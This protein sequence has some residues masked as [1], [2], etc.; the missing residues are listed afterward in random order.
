MNAIY[1]D[2][3]STTPVHP[4][5]AAAI[6]RCFQAGHVNPASSHRP[7]QHA[8]RIVEKARHR[9]AATLGAQTSGTHADH[10]IFTSGGTEA[11]NLALRGLVPETG[12]GRIII[13][14]I[15][16]PSVVGSAQ[17]LAHCG[18][19]IRRVRVSGQGVVDVKHLEELL[20]DDT[21]LVSVMLGNNETGVLQPVKEIAELCSRRGVPL[22][23]DAVQVVGK[24]PVAFR[25]LGASAL[26]ATAH[27]FHGPRGVGVVLLRHG[28]PL[29]PIMYGGFQQ[30]GLRP[31][32]ESVEL[33]VG[34][35][36]A[37]QIW[38]AEAH[39][40][41]TDMARLR[42]GLERQLLLEIPTAVV[43]GAGAARLPHTSNISFP[44][45]DRQAL[46]MALDEAG[47]ACSTGSACASGS[48]QPSPVLLAM[49]CPD[50][51]VE[52]AIRLSVGALTTSAEV[53]LAGCRISRVVQDLY[54]A[55]ESGYSALGPRDMADKSI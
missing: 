17:Q 20:T 3:N 51:I 22:H 16:H 35:S 47:V 50:E 2:N 41:T 29:K 1:L 37:L 24:I 9:I 40:R 53:R 10:V 34:M 45:L 15:E 30:R 5:V 44:G 49:G 7:G 8:R 46:L 19:D 43:N 26:T 42:D 55:Q 11:N 6:S 18:Y 4:D 32:T 48:S 38:L 13:S 14:A 25:E 21:V 23:T 33:V 54:A 36:E 31:G 52:G 39:Q 12:P 28:V 27:K